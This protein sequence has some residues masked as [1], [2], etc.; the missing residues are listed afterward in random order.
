MKRYTPKTTTV[1]VYD[2]ANCDGCGRDLD[3]ETTGESRIH[4]VIISVD[5][6]SDDGKLDIYDY[7]DMC[8]DAWKPLLRAAGSTA[9]SLDAGHP[10]EEPA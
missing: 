5:E 9:P 10:E 1:Q 6:D 7:C 2:G 3:A 8:F 4:E